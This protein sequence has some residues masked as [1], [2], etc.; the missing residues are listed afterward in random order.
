MDG[1]N[2]T[3]LEGKSSPL[4]SSLCCVRAVC[5]VPSWKQ[6]E[7]LSPGTEPSQPSEMWGNQLPFCKN[8][9]VLEQT[10]W[11]SLRVDSTG[12]SS[13]SYFSNLNLLY[14]WFIWVGVCQFCWFFFST[15][16]IQVFSNIPGQ[17]AL[18]VLPTLRSSY[19]EYALCSRAPFSRLDHTEVLREATINVKELKWYE[20]WAPLTLNQFRDQKQTSPL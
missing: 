20:V 2:V 8:T 13:V 4:Q 11:D 12:H 18:R 3:G 10:D 16:N 1:S 15:G 14:S 17:L 5:K 9:P 19:T 7:E 6:K